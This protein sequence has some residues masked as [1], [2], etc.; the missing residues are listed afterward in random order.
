[1]NEPAILDAS[2]FEV[3]GWLVWYKRINESPTQNVYAI[4]R[5]DQDSITIEFD[6]QDYIYKFDRLFSDYVQYVGPTENLEH[7]LLAWKLI[8]C[9]NSSKNW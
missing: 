9:D 7:K 6:G 2:K 3:G 4:S 5:V 8:Y 1:M